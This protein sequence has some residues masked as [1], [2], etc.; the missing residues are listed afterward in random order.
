MGHV[1]KPVPRD[2]RRGWF[3]RGSID[4]KKPRPRLPTCYDVPPSPPRSKTF[5]TRMPNEEPEVC[6]SWNLL[7]KLVAHGVFQAPYGYTLVLVQ[8][9]RIWVLMVAIMG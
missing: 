7:G 9:A 3:T 6:D 4:P 5:S 2:V 8:E 1:P